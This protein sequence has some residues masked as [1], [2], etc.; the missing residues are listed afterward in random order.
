MYI[1]DYL[2]YS[3]II[4]SFSSKTLCLVYPP[5][6]QETRMSLIGLAGR[7]AKNAA[8]EDRDG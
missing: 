8:G 6:G 4:I 3:L 5:A 1:L 7:S 2:R